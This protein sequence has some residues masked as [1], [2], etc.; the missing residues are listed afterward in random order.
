MTWFHSLHFE[1]ECFSQIYEDYRK[2]QSMGMYE[3]DARGLEFIDFIVVAIE[4]EGS[5]KEQSCKE[6]I[7]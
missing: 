1:S 7:F 5:F 3:L 2:F 6:G 4:K